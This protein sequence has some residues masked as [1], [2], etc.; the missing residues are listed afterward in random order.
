MN[1]DACSDNVP[2]NFML[3]A[4]KYHSFLCSLLSSSLFYIFTF[5]VFHWLKGVWL[6]LYN[7]S[8]PLSCLFCVCIL[9][10]SLFSPFACVLF[11]VPFRSYNNNS[12]IWPL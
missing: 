1:C 9:S 7:L 5:F 3:N 11:L 10:I 4:I 2:L 8:V 12:N 6:A